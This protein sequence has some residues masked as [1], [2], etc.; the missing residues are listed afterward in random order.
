MGDSDIEVVTARGTSGV[1][2]LRLRAVGTRHV[3]HNGLQQMFT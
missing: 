3:A 1:A 2:G